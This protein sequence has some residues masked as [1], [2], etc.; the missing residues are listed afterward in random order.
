MKGRKKVVG[1]V[2]VE[3]QS[4][5]LILVNYK[6]CKNHLMSDFLNRHLNSRHGELCSQ[7]DCYQVHQ[8]P[9]IAVCSIADFAENRLKRILSQIQLPREI[10]RTLDQSTTKI[11]YDMTTSSHKKNNTS[12]SVYFLFL[13]T[14][15]HHHNITR[16]DS[17]TVI[18]TPPSC[19][20]PIWRTRPSANFTFG[21]KC[22]FLPYCC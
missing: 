8:Q 12:V 4:C 13:L 6:I 21:A 3:M 20:D 1:K 22:R 14:H 2:N 15:Q 7:L 16:S 5:I 17:V 18:L 9:M 11:S 19:P 10:S